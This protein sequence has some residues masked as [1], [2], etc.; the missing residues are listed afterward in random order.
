MRPHPFKLY[1]NGRPPV[2]KA[3][4]Q[5]EFQW[6][7]CNHRC[8]VIASGNLK[9][10]T[11]RRARQAPAKSR[12][13][14]GRRELA[15]SHWQA[16]FKLDQLELELDSELTYPLRAKEEYLHLLEINKA[17]VCGSE[18]DPSHRRCQA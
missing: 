13:A 11:V 16:V 5:F 7:R 18:L 14:P 3:R 8:P 12:R 6:C 15:G 4:W 17:N 9:A 10:W 1:R 2:L